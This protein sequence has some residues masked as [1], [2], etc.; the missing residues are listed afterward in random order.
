MV[1]Q[2]HQCVGGDAG[3]VERI[4]PSCLSGSL[5]GSS[6]P[7]FPSPPSNSTAGG[8]EAVSRKA[9]GMVLAATATH[10][11]RLGPEDLSYIKPSLTLKEKA[12]AVAHPRAVRDE[13]KV[14]RKAHLEV[15]LG[16]GAAVNVRNHHRMCEQ[17]ARHNLRRWRRKLD[18]GGGCQR[19]R[20]LFSGRPRRKSIRS[21]HH[22]TE[23]CACALP[24]RK[25]SIPLPQR[26]RARLGDDGPVER[27][28]R[29][30]AHEGREVET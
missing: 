22:T 20:V 19:R 23:A 27:A 15:L 6:A 26:Q 13:L 12:V 9:V 4:T 11:K 21:P 29:R 18:G 24:L 30:E 25:T 8:A 28:L 2:S 14:V 1:S 5:S 16:E 17:L 3:D 7:P 10:A